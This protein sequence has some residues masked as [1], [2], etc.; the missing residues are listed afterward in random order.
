MRL[1]FGA[2]CVGQALHRRAARDQAREQPLRRDHLWQ[3]SGHLQRGGLLQRAL[4]RA[5]LALRHLVRVRV[6]VR[7]RVGVGVRVRVTVGVRVRVGVGVRVGVR[8]TV[9][10]GDLGLD[11]ALRHRGAQPRDRLGLE[12]ELLFQRLRLLHELACTLG[13]LN[14]DWAAGAG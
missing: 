14:T 6:M 3:P 1:G 5:D 4:E 7:V 12:G 8:V 13:V 10:V 9:R 2:H 11:V